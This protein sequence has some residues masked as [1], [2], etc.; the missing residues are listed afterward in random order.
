M[1][2]PLKGEVAFS[3]DGK[4][5]VLVFD[6]NAL[7]TIS[8]RLGLT[9]DEIGKDLTKDMTPPFLRSALWAGLEEFHPELSER[10][11]GKLITAMG[12]G[13]A[14]ARLLQSVA[15]AFPNSEAPATGDPQTAAAP[16]PTRRRRGTS[17][18]SS[19]SGAD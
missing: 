7:C 1:A 15:L 5:F 4:D 3:V 2:N 13:E 11:V 10:D 12:P 19:P 17:S 14:R 8:G 6:W 18:T 9:M 16:A